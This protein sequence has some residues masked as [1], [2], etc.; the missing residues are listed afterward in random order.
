M[1][2]YLKT[3][4]R[5]HR[6]IVQPGKEAPETSAFLGA[7]GQPLTFT[8]RFAAG[9]AEVR[10]ELGKWLVAKGM[11]NRTLIIDPAM[12]RVL[13]AQEKR[14]RTHRLFAEPLTRPS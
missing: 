5:D 1:R 2:V 7:D 9:V 8:V 14:V 12:E 3:G 4:R 6:L 11:V 10:P 13:V